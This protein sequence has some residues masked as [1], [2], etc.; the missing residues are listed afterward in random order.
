MMKAGVMGWPIS[1]SLS[2]RVH[3]Y[4]LKHHGIDGSYEAMAVESER[5]ESALRAL[6]E[7]GFRGVNLTIPHKEAALKLVD[8]VDPLAQTV[9]AINTVIVR[10]DGTLEGRNTDVFG[11]TENLHAAGF[12]FDRAY[13]NGANPPI[14]TILGAGGAARAVVSALQ[15]M[16]FSN[17]R[18]VN[19]SIERAKQLA[20]E[21][22][23]NIAVFSWDEV[24]AAVS[25]TALLVNTTSMGMAGQPPM[26]VHIASLP[27]E[28]WVTDLVYAPLK[29]EL[30]INAAAKGLRCVDG[31][32][33]LLHQAR[34]AF[35]AWF[36]VDPEVTEALRK[37]VLEG[38]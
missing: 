22:W 27:K 20:S 15:Q 17:I 35:K 11:F 38:T 34:P 32:G 10:K 14:A 12:R 24:D 37:H 30:L 18:I 9:G 3:G 1:H 13:N 31:L 29:T 19:R 23:G 4:W 21:M 25:G 2:P 7:N 36:G 28:A 6:P 5:L 8:Y 26:R 16:G 33:M